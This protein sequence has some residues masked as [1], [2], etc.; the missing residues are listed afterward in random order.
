MYEFGLQQLSSY[1]YCS[2]QLEGLLHNAQ[3]EWL[4]IT[5]F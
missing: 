2:V 4:T 3:C 1:F 5:K